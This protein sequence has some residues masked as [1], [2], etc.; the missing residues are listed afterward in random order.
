MTRREYIL[1]ASTK[2][3]LFSTVTVPP[4]PGNRCMS[5]G[6][7]DVSSYSV[8]TE[9]HQLPFGAAAGVIANWRSRDREVE[10]LL[11]RVQGQPPTLTRQS[12]TVRV[13]LPEIFGS[14]VRT[15]LSI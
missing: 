4:V 8:L 3:S 6:T 5:A 7:S 9:L 14:P 12:P 1:V 10:I 13:S 11:K 2:T 15:L